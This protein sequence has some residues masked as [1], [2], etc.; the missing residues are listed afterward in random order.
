MRDFI[1]PIA[2]PCIATFFFVPP[3]KMESYEYVQSRE[4]VGKSDLQILVTLDEPYTK[5]QRTEKS[6]GFI[7]I[8]VYWKITLDIKV[9]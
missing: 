8:N 7:G 1:S 2:N 4:D 6:F 3:K 9:Q 5:H